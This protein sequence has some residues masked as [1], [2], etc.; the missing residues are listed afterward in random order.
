MLIEKD[1][2]K[3]QAGVRMLFD[4]YQR[5]L[6]GFLGDRFPDLNE[7]ERASAIDDVFIGIY[8]KAVDGSLNTDDD[9]SGL[10]FTIARRR[11]LDSRRKNARRIPAGAKLLE[12]V[13]DY[14]KETEVGSDWRLAA[15]LEKTHEVSD[16]FRR[17][18]RTLKAV[19]QRRVASVM[20]DALPDW[21]TDRE[22]AE[23]VNTRFGIHLSQLEVKGAKQAFVTKF[24]DV[25]KRR[26]K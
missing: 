13:G 26:L 9:L 8:N 23:E 19:Q 2:D 16:E 3:K 6:M 20:A 17:L 22:I 4:R 11:A 18:V 24:R 7:D 1:D 14:L 10:I 25:L 12:E 21:L 15:I 5:P